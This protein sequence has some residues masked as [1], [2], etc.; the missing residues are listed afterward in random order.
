FGHGKM[1]AHDTHQIALM[2]SIMLVGLVF[3]AVNT[4]LLS[5]F[6]GLRDMRTP[7]LAGLAV[8]VGFLIAGALAPGLQWLAVAVAAFHVLLCLLLL[9]LLSKSHGV[10]LGSALINPRALRRTCAGIAAFAFVGVPLWMVVSG[11]VPR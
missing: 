8:L 10:A 1:T 9:T 2:S 3:Q 4:M 6:N 7:F 5:F 11:T